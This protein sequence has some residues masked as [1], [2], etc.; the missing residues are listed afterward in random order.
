MRL[1][2]SYEV[3]MEA[4]RLLEGLPQE[5]RVAEEFLAWQLRQLQQEQE[6]L[7]ILCYE[8]VRDQPAPN[9]FPNAVKDY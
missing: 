9:S 7:A 1:L 4:S 8:T 2:V 3:L 5:V 6:E